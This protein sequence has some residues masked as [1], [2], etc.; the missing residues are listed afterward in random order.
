MYKKMYTK[1]DNMVSDYSTASARYVL[2]FVLWCSEPIGIL[3]LRIS[4]RDV[5]HVWS[6]L[7]VCNDDGW[8]KT[9]KNH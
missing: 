9:H 6:R 2:K 1:Y 8:N 7:I 4:S 5:G 3:G